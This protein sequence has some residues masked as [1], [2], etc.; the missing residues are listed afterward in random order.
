MVYLRNATED[1]RDLLFYWANDP[2]VRN[3]SFNQDPI[4]FESH[5]KWF[6]RLMK[7]SSEKQFILM[8]GDVAVGQVRLNIID[9]E[10]EIGYSIASEVRGCGYGSSIIRLITELVKEQF[11]QISKLIA[12]VKPENEASIKIFE[13]QG[14]SINYYCFSLS[15]K[16]DEH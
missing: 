2:V 6:D 9:D 8:D 1:D 10:A 5:I 15:T 11:P 16:E 3:C 14:F 7:E 12:K 13:K 4:P